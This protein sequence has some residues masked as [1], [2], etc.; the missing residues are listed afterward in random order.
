[1]DPIFFRGYQIS[2]EEAVEAENC[3]MLQLALE[4][5][6]RC[7]IDHHPLSQRVKSRGSNSGI[8]IDLSGRAAF[9]PKSIGSNK[10]TFG[11]SPMDESQDVSSRD[12]QL[13]IL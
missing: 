12:S 11:S 8:S 10:H 4:G 6:Y 3:E 5:Q 13:M 9:P 1:M 7:S 2:R